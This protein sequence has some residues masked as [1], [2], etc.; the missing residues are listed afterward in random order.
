[1]H[2]I[3]IQMPDA[4]NPTHFAYISTHL[5]KADAAISL[6]VF[7]VH[8]VGG[9]LPSWLQALAP[10]APRSEKVDHHCKHAHRARIAVSTHVQ[11]AV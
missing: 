1:V 8:L 7:I 11:C 6:W 9:R 4:G 10:M 2:L 3:L 5:G